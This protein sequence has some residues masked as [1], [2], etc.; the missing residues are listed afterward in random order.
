MKH[1]RSTRSKDVVFL[2]LRIRAAGW[3][4]QAARWPQLPHAI[5]AGTLHETSTS[6]LARTRGRFDDL[7]LFF[8][9]VVNGPLMT[10]VL[11]SIADLNI[12]EQCGFLSAFLAAQRFSSD[13]DPSWCPSTYTGVSVIKTFC[14]VEKSLPRRDGEDEKE[15]A[16]SSRKFN[17]D[18]EL[19]LPRKSCPP[20]ATPC[21]GQQL[22]TKLFATVDAASMLFA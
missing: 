8:V 12:G 9:S 17:L 21:E 2:P 16:S 18:L 3:I 5:L 20:R 4:G 15:G 14:G 19:D 11:A 10:G 7:R 6:S 1:V 13:T 22:R